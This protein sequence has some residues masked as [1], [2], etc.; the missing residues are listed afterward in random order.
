MITTLLT[1]FLSNLNLFMFVGAFALAA[2]CARGKAV[3]MFQIE[4]L[5]WVIFLSGGIMG[6]YTFV[7]HVF[8]FENCLSEYRLGAQPF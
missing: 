4:L 2:F 8:F 3:G 1:L 7:L 6:L 5:R